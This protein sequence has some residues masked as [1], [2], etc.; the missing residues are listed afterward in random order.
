MS[1]ESSVRSYPDAALIG[2]IGQLQAMNYLDHWSKE[3]LKLL[4]D[5]YRQRQI[6]KYKP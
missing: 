3:R 5:E 6:Q 2:A 4:R 1:A